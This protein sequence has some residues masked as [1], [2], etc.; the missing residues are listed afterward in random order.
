[1]STP[2][3]VV[4]L[5]W[6]SQSSAPTSDNF[7]IVWIYDRSA[8]ALDLFVNTWA[9]RTTIVGFFIS[10]VGFVITIQQVMKAK[11]LTQEVN[12]AVGGVRDRLRFQAASEQF[13][14]VL[15]EL[16]ELKILHR[17][18][19]VEVLPQRYTSIKRKLAAIKQNERLSNAQM[20]QVQSSITVFSQIENKIEKS[21]DGRTGLTKASELNRIA[22]EQADKLHGILT[23]LMKAQGEIR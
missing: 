3:S 21:I 17:K 19:V 6:N 22:T 7:G 11:S 14:S 1:M 20:A 23:E 13:Q 8:P 10:I 9:N 12:V 16:D 5:G 15:F 18:D 4:L 2:M